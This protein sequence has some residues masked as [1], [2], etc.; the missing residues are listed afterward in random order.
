M[1]R[2]KTAPY[3]LYVY[4]FIP[5]HFLFF[6]CSAIASELLDQLWNEKNPRLAATF[7]QIV[8]YDR[9]NTNDGFVES[10]PNER[11]KILY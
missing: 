4:A 6:L 1:Q 9:V 5:I 2:N 8:R 11:V 10:L 7:N 3:D